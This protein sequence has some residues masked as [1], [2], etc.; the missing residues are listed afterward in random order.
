MC[1]TALNF[2]FCKFAVKKVCNLIKNDKSLQCPYFIGYSLSTNNVL[3]EGLS[4][5]RWL[6]QKSK[7]GRHLKT[8]SENS[9]PHRK[10]PLKLTAK[11]AKISR[12]SGRICSKTNKVWFLKQNRPDIR[13]YY[14]I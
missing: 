10:T 8:Q 9:P 6:G 1:V 4:I 12:F 14:R 2:S 5:S 11:Y 13:A 3:Q 7:R